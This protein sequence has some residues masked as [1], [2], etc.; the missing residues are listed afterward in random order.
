MVQTGKHTGGGPCREKDIR[1]GGLG[2]PRGE[3]GGGPVEMTE[4]PSKKK[5][6]VMG[7]E[8]GGPQ[9]QL[10]AEEDGRSLQGKV[11][12]GTDA[13]VDHDIKLGIINILDGTL[14][15]GLGIYGLVN[16]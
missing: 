12:E 11:E 4:A 13:A 15:E 10:M 16:G 1:K 14:V 8:F 9:T 7:I 6:T 3:N 5:S 2:K